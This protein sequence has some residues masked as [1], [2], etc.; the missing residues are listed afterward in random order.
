MINDQS[1]TIGH[2]SRIC[3]VSV[4]TLRYYDNVGLLCPSRTD[5]FTHYRYYSNMDILLV[6]IVRD[7]KSLRFSLEEIGSIL[8]QS[9]LD[10]LTAALKSKKQETLEEIERLQQVY[11]SIENRIG[12]LDSLRDLNEK[13][14]F[15]GEGVLIELKQLSDRI[16][17]F[18]RR[19]AV[20]G[21]EASVVRFTHLFD[22][23]EKHG[24]TAQ[25]QLMSIYHEN[26]LT[27]DRT[28]S[29]IEVSILLSSDSLE[30]PFIRTLTGGY[31]ITA[32]Y[33]GPPN[34][35][36]C[37]KVYRDL[38]SWMGQHGYT[39]CGPAVELYVVDLSQIRDPGEFIVELQVPVEKVLTL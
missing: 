10:G 17:A 32:T 38:L 27:F 7:L 14:D 23:L 24:L 21:M 12:Q 28:D 4:Q 36:S 31:Y 33:S 15:E 35:E 9:G 6:K 11:A 39:E 22:Q 34:E 2:V 1:Y 26:L 19:R 37:K 30:N 16:I 20:C 25:G 13:L 29:D 5:P 3:G 18:E 8:K